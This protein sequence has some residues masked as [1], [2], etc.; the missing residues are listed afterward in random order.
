MSYEL[1]PNAWNDYFAGFSKKSGV[2]GPIT[3]CGISLKVYMTITKGKPGLGGGCRR[4]FLIECSDLQDAVIRSVD[5]QN[6]CLK[7]VQDAVRWFCEEEGVEVDLN[8]L[9]ISFDHFWWDT[10]EEL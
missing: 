1:Y 7:E 5:P 6:S 8:S 4:F 2:A 10:I 9:E 3:R